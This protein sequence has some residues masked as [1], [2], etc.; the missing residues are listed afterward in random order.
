[1]NQGQ[2]IHKRIR[3]YLPLILSFLQTKAPVFG[4]KT[5]AI[6]RGRRFDKFLASL[7]AYRLTS[8]IIKALAD[9]IKP[10]TVIQPERQDSRGLG[11]MS[12]PIQW[13]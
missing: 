2:R 11:T 4:R 5:E 6:S 3:Y 7:I 8:N 13:P 1:M 9:F 10:I 12:H